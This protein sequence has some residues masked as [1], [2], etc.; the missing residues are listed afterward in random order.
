M[1]LNENQWKAIQICIQSVVTALL[2]MAQTLLSGCV[3]ADN[4]SSVVVD[5]QT[6]IS[7]PINIPEG[8]FD[9]GVEKYD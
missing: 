3:S 7:V 4:G 1:K 9:I 8:V 5:K 6:E 2:L